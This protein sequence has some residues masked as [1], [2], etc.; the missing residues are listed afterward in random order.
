GIGSL[1]WQGIGDTIR[2]SL[3]A[4]PVEEVKVGWQILK[5]LRLRKRGIDIT[6]CP[7][8]ARKGIDVINI[9]K[10]LEQ[11]TAKMDKALRIA[12]MGCGV[13]G[14]G[15]AKEADIGVV[16]GKGNVLLYKDGMMVGTIEGNVV[17]RLMKEIEGM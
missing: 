4:D 15:E 11:R 13:N 1:L 10:E 6:S 5:S 12:V 7:T 9:V 8:C 16:G 3:S 17:E 2:V 14:P